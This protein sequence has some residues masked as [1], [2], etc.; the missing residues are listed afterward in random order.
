LKVSIRLG[1]EFRVG[2]ACNVPSDKGWPCKLT[3]IMPSS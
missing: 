2:P 1:L 3:A